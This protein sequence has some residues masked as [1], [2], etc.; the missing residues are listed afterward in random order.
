MGHYLID[1]LSNVI[2]TSN[3]TARS[4]AEMF[5]TP[6]WV[7]P[8]NGVWYVECGAQL[9]QNVGLSFPGQS[10]ER[11]FLLAK[12]DMKIANSDGRCISAFQA[13][14]SDNIFRLGWPFLKNTVIM[15]DLANVPTTLNITQRVL[16]EA[17][18]LQLV[19][20]AYADVRRTCHEA[21]AATRFRG[22]ALQRKL[23]S[24]VALP[25]AEI[26]LMT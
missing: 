12:E 14:G 16:P 4:V 21:H 11:A 15:F 20:R 26:Q 25:L 22:P 18:D 13:A 7:D 23:R 24:R 2:R 3:A 10:H 5:R 17:K 6:G 19:D 9:T 1:S 8:I